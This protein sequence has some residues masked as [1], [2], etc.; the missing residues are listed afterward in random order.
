MIRT[1]IATAGMAALAAAPAFAQTTFTPPRFEA[2]DLQKQMQEQ[3]RIDHLEQQKQAAQA[4]VLN[5]ANHISQ[6][7]DAI[8]QLKL[9]EQTNRILLENQQERD[10]IARENTINE[11]AVPNRRIAP[12]SILV[13]NNPSAYALPAAPKGQYYARLN[14]H[15]VLVDRAS[16]LV[17]KVLD[18]Q[19]G[20]PTDDRPEQPRPPLQP[21][22]PADR[23]GH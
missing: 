10:R 2:L 17:V 18:D 21:P 6:A 7:D 23:I 4:K 12:S 3:N 13:V 9:N 5:P 8:T 11:L 20:Y 15:F 16:E 19:P 14:G 1:L 22:V